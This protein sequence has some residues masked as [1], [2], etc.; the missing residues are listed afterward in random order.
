M[1]PFRNLWAQCSL[2]IILSSSFGV[3]AQIPN[4]I[5][6]ANLSSSSNSIASERT[7]HA[8]I[9]PGSPGGRRPSSSVSAANKVAEFAELSSLTREYR[10]GAGDVLDIRVAGLDVR[11][12]TLF[13]ISADGRLDYP[14]VTQP[15]RVSGLTANEIEVRLSREIK[16]LEKPRLMVSVREYASHLVIASGL[17]ATPGPVTLRREAIPLFA[18]LAQIGPTANATKVVLARSG[19]PDNEIS[20][21][22]QSGLNTLIVS[23]DVIK[24]AGPPKRLPFFFIGGAV[25]SPGQKEY[26]DG[27]TLTQ[28]VLAAGGVQTELA[29]RVRLA[30]QGHDGKLLTK[31]FDLSEIKAG[32][33]VDPDV[34]AGDRIELYRP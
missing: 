1:S 12:S 25:N 28:A 24:V 26:Y 16:I 7:V 18:L 31:G 2:L 33:A 17:V 4:G 11:D 6:S 30:R 21:A 29:T 10:V 19:Q 9:G 3:G 34:E 13:T 8:E 22:D 5:S 27:L 32:I 23:G 14:L 15:M 20:L